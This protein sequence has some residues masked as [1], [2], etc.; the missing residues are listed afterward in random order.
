M[1]SEIVFGQRTTIKWRNYDGIVETRYVI[2]LSVRCESVSTACD[3]VK[4]KVGNT[5]PEWT[6]YCV[7]LG[8]L[9]RGAF[10]SFALARLEVVK[11]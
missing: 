4:A 8:R 10:R 6:L 1:I 3:K 5:P 11:E 7:D 9:D 2:P